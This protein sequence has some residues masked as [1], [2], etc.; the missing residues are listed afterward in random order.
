VKRI[1][2]KRHG[3][4]SHPA[5]GFKDAVGGEALFEVLFEDRKGRYS[6]QRG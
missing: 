6:R 2:V 1:Q 4:R 3:L 5:V